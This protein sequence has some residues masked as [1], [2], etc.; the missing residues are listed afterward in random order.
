RFFRKVRQVA[1]L[2]DMDGGTPAKR[3]KRCREVLIGRPEFA[4]GIFN[5]DRL[6]FGNRPRKFEIKIIADANIM[7]FQRCIQ[8]APFET[9][10][11]NGVIGSSNHYCELICGGQMQPA[12]ACNEIPL[13]GGCLRLGG[14]EGKFQ[15]GWCN[16]LQSGVAWFGQFEGRGVGC[17][18]VCG[19]A[20]GAELEQA[21]DA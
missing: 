16:T 3:I 17:G 4:V 13:S 9:N 10:G 8:H 1:N 18:R 7:S 20:I 19:R 21:D 11:D 15:L 5:L 6:M 2:I 14:D 12:I